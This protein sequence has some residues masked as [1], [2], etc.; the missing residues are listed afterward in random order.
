MTELFMLTPVNENSIQYIVDVYEKTPSGDVRT[1]TV[2]E[3]YRSGVGY[4]DVTDPVHMHEADGVVCNVDSHLSNGF[5][6]LVDVQFEFDDTITEREKFKI[7]NQWYPKS[8]KPESAMQ[9]L[10]KNDIWYI[11]RDLVYVGGPFTIDVID[12]NGTIV[13]E[14][15]KPD[16]NYA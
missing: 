5:S 9:W 2:T 6:D 1:W 14:N 12:H 3:Y 16:V 8:S 15:L 11:E 13:E 7:V 4:R 10:E